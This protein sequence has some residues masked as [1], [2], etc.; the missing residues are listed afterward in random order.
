MKRDE[1]LPS[2]LPDTT[3]PQMFMITFDVESSAR[4]KDL[5]N[6]G[7]RLDHCGYIS[8]EAGQQAIKSLPGLLKQTNNRSFD[9]V[10]SSNYGLHLTN[11]ILAKKGSFAVR[12]EFTKKKPSKDAGFMVTSRNFV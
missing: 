3:K 1:A 6:Y 9:E 11:V 5:I 8:A 2:V 7:I 10:S 12:A 4:H